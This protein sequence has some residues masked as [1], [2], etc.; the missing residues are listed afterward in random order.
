MSMT[1][2]GLAYVFC[3]NCV[4]LYRFI[5]LCIF[6]CCLVSFVGTLAKWLAGKTYSHDIFRVEGFPLQ[7][8]YWRV[9]YCNGLLYV[10]P[11]HNVVNFSLTSL[12]SCNILLKARCSLF[13]LKVPL[14]A[15][16]S[17]IQ[18]VTWLLESTQFASPFTAYHCPA[19]DISVPLSEISCTYHVSDST[20]TAAPGLCSCWSVWCEI[21]SGSLHQKLLNSVHFSVSYSK[22]KRGGAIFEFTIRWC[23]ISSGFCTPKIIKIG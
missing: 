1:K 2:S 16:Q 23:E 22:Y 15:N 19:R 18:S 5:E 21:S 13:V 10:F 7:R 3:V 8:P 9:I 20:R 17:I 4:L 11:T 12:F 14:N 6:L